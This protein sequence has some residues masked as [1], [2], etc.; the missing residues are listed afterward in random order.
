MVLLCPANT[1]ALHL[2][3]K[4]AAMYDAVDSMRIYEHDT[5]NGKQYHIAILGEND[6]DL[7]TEQELIDLLEYN[8]NEWKKGG[9]FMDKNVY[10]ARVAT[11]TEDAYNAYYTREAAE[12]QAR[13]W[14]NHLTERERKNHTVSVEMYIITAEQ[15]QTAKEA[16]TEAIYH[17]MLTD[18]VEYTEIKASHK[19][20]T[21]RPQGRLFFLCA[22]YRL[23]VLFSRITG[24]YC[25]AYHG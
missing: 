9:F 12:K 18:P 11:A 4:A 2:T 6:S 19:P 5:E 16:Y 20:H 10:I 1:T 14:Y 3:G 21:S 17:D 13:E 25:R 7:M 24:L 23:N 15:D 8:Y 22:C